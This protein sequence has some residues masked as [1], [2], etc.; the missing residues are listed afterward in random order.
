MDADDEHDFITKLVALKEIW[1]SK[2]QEFLVCGSVPKFYNYIMERVSTTLTRLII[3]IIKNKTFNHINNDNGS[4]HFI[5][6][7]EILFLTQLKNAVIPVRFGAP[8]S[9]I[10]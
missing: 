8:I 4:F 7:G 10:L 9:E 3:K 6:F 1:N 5:R 2:E